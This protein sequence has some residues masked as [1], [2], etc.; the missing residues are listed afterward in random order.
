MGELKNVFKIL[1]EKSEGSM[2]AHRHVDN[3]EMDCREIGL[4]VVD[5]IHLAQE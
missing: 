3:I 2:P 4:E 1:V 5:W